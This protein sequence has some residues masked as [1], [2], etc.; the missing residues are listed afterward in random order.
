[1]KNIH[2]TS[3]SKLA[4]TMRSTNPFKKMCVGNINKGMGKQPVLMEWV[5]DVGYREQLSRFVK[6]ERASRHDDLGPCYVSV[7]S[8]IKTVRFGGK[9]VI[10]IQDVLKR[11]KTFHSERKPLSYW[12]FCGEVKL[13]ILQ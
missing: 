13:P 1:M 3:T 9:L 8:E 5:S 10:T 12:K 11:G 7:S 4:L 6:A 2:F